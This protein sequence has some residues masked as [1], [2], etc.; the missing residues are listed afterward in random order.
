MKMM[1]ITGFWV[2]DFR[3]PS[4]RQKLGKEK[5]KVAFVFKVYFE[6]FSIIVQSLPRFSQCYQFR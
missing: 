4:A 1:F 6:K 5:I 2:C 3:G